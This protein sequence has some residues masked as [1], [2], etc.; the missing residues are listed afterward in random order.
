MWVRMVRAVGH[1]IMGNRIMENREPLR[2]GVITKADCQ[3]GRR[4]SKWQAWG[5]R[6]DYKRPIFPL[7][8][9]GGRIANRVL[10]PK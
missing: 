4:L 9:G 2:P 5:R 3:N 7:H 1:R 8:G 6:P 10:L